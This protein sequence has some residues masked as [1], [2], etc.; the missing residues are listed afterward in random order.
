MLIITPLTNNYPNRIN[1]GYGLPNKI[2]SDIRDIP[3]MKCGC[4]GKDT[5]DKHEIK[6]FLNS[7]HAGS[8]RALENT[9]LSNYADTEAFS[10]IKL[11]SEVQPKE[12]IRNLI[13]VQENKSKIKSLSPRTQLDINMIALIS[14]GISVKAPRVMKKL[15]KFRHFF[16]AEDNAILELMDVYALK[17]PKKTFAEIFNL[18]EVAKYHR[19]IHDLN[20]KTASTQRINVFKRLKEFSQT[21]TP[22]D[23]KTLQKT[24]SNVITVL[25]QDFIQPHLKKG[26]VEDLYE[27]FMKNARGKISKR[28]LRN[29]IKEFPYTGMTPDRFITENV[30]N[31]R[32]DMDIV[33]YFVKRLQ[34]TEEHFKARSKNGTDTKDNIII[35]CQKCNEERSNLPYPFFLR[36]HPEMIQNL[37]KQINKIITFIKHGKLVGYDDYPADIK[38]NVLTGS[39]NLIRLK[40]GD[41]LKFRKELA[42]RELERSQAILA[43]DTQTFETAQGNLSD[44]N[45]KIEELEAQIRT[46]KKE[47]RT[48]KE[49]FTVAEEVKNRS[50]NQVRMNEYAL[51]DAQEILNTDREVNQSLK[52]K[53]RKLKSK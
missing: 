15:E 51:E 1:F 5:L 47:K 48:I 37:Q 14:D 2:F 42:A 36:F 41:Y 52:Y 7:F 13:S 33:K 8:K 17:Y 28:K 29:I 4:C 25:N 53:R 20:T 46:L 22:E 40:I 6:H 3:R 18:T 26:L 43:N 49:E 35:L 12:T 50:E 19:E 38:T 23:A 30:A 44:I 32:S 34:A 24:N 31:Q 11:L 21:L 10:F 45:T 9:A 27:S 16:G 39:D